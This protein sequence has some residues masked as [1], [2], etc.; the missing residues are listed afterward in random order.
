MTSS[1]PLSSSSSSPGRRRTSPPLHSTLLRED[2]DEVLESEVFVD[3]NRLR[4][5]ARHGI[6]DEIRGEVWKFLLGVEKPDR[7]SEFTQRRARFESYREIDKENVETSK[8]VR[9]EVNRYLTRTKKECLLDP[10]SSP[11]I[12]EA[13]ICAY[14]NCNNNIDY[15]P[16]LVQI[17]APFVITMK[18]EHDVFSCFERLVNTLYEPSLESSINK[19][20]AQFLSYFRTLMPELYNYFEDEELDVGEWASSWLRF[21]L[22]KELPTACVLSLWDVYFSLPDFI[23]FHPFVCLAILR[24]LKD[25]LED[26][27][28]S[29]IRSMLLRLPKMNISRIVSQAYNIRSEIQARYGSITTVRA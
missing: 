13:V 26:L 22:A 21:L 12:F 15:S 8:R 20:V 25:S 9:G 11:A 7:S 6:P 10:H 24:H 19:R 2:F 18:S 14:L 1:P 28:Q 23:D 27:E 4:K 17:C 3:V 5:Y 16:A 29:E